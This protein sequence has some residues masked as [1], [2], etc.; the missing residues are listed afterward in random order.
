MFSAL[1]ETTQLSVSTDLAEPCY[2]LL[3]FYSSAHRNT[4]LDNK[5]F[6]AGI[7]KAFSGFTK[8]QLIAQKVPSAPLICSRPVK[9]KLGMADMG[10]YMSI[11]T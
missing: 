7:C 4:P 2:T 6:K 1:K 9:H 5:L 8:P 11:S 10:P 3:T